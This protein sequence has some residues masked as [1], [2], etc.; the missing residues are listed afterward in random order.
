[1]TGRFAFSI[2]PFRPGDTEELWR[3]MRANLASNESILKTPTQTAD[4]AMNDM[5]I[6]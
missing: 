5:A 3:L 2:R 6:A 4:H 1:M